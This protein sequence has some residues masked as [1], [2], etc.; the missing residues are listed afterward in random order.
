MYYLE[1]I[2]RFWIFN[3]KAKP[4]STAIAM[5]LYLLKTAKACDAYDFK[6]SDVVLGKEL[7]L[8][9][10]TVKTAKEKLRDLGLIRFQ[11]KNGV[12]G[13]YRLIL[14]YPLEAIAPEK[15]KSSEIQMTP[16]FQELKDDLNLNVPNLGVKITSSN[17]DQKINAQSIKPANE[18]SNIPVLEEFLAY[19]RTLAAYQSE[20]DELIK[21]KYHSWK[22][23][24]W[25]NN[26]DRLITNWK[27]SLKST[28]PFLKNAAHD[29]QL[30][31]QTIP[32]IKR[33]K[34]NFGK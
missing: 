3:E 18:N 30:S 31:I 23:S 5:Y 14:S 11:T 21:D 12:S 1:L 8:T 6:V 13:S 20:L 17:I 26:S 33:P 15:V 9:R 16:P 7:G 29:D 22:D 34:S 25:K 4:G 27:S 28:L 10:P 32:D 19:A 24:G 2:E